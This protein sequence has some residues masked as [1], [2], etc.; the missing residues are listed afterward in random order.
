[1][2]SYLNKAIL[3][4]S[5]GALAI[6]L[7]ACEPVPGQGTQN[8][9]QGALIGAG[10]GAVGGLLTGDD[11]RERARNAVIGAA[12]GATVGGVAGT[13]LDRQ[14]AELRNQL[15]SNVGIV[16]NGTSLTV[17]MPNDILFPVDS[18]T[19]TGQLQSDL[20]ALAQSLNN[21]PN[22]RVQV[23]GHTDSDGAAAYNQDL[24]ERRAQSVASVLISAGVA[25]GRISTIGR[26]EAAPIASNLDAAGKARNR[27]VEVVITPNG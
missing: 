27:R 23:I 18:A 26:G 4:L 25:P 7:A 24:S 19:L 3:T 16:N 10:I 1:M 22:S 15:G 14:E 5:G 21:Y 8:A 11:S 12:A 6:G 2:Q 9:N 13:I 17:T 20:R